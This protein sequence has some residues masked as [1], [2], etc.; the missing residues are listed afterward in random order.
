MVITVGDWKEKPLANAKFELKI[1]D[2]VGNLDLRQ[3]QFHMVDI[4]MP[5]V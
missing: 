3:G 1:D 4:C 2:L 5:Q